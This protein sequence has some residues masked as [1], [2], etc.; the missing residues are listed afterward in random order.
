MKNK[1]S[2]KSNQ[3]SLIIVISNLLKKICE[4]S[5]KKSKEKEKIN[6]FLSKK[7]PLISI[8]KFFE[9]ICKL[10]KIENS[11]LI[12][13]MIFIDRI[14]ELNEIELNYFNIHKLIIGSLIISIKYNED[15]FFSNK[16]YAK[17]C[18]ISKE[19]INKIEIQFLKLLKFNLFVNHEIYVQ[20]S[21]FI[22]N[23]NI[24]ISN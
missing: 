7:I 10:T 23:E 3:N 5:S 1:N 20:Y 18:G 9:R 22:L 24:N 8:E 4:K 12:L 17:I 13:I 15:Y 21:Q 2:S 16:I 6:P 19:E 14:C 11:T